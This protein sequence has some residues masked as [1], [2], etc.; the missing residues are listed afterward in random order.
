MWAGVGSNSHISVRVPV[1]S[2]RRRLVTTERADSLFTF[3]N[4]TILN[5]IG[6]DS[7]FPD[8]SNK[9]VA[10]VRAESY[11]LCGHSDLK[12]ALWKPF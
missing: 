3:T 11:Y 6:A 8:V 1:Y 5:P 10:A 2:S 12:I 4:L 9:Q 7:N